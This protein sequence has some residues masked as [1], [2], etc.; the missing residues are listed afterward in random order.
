MSPVL[1]SPVLPSDP[2]SIVSL[3][4]NPEFRTAL[5]GFVIDLVKED[6]DFRE[7]MREAFDY[8]AATSDLKI[9]KRLAVVETDLGHNDLADFEEGHKPTIPEQIKMLSDR[10]EQPLNKSNDSI[11]IE[12]PV[13]PKTTLEHKAGELV[14]HLKTNVKP[15]NG[16]VFL[17]SREIMTFL[18]NEIKEEYQMK[19]IQNPRQAK[20][21]I[22]EKAKKMFSDFIVLD[23]K[24]HGNKDIRIVYK[25][26]SDIMSRKCMN[27]YIHL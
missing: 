23:K 25:P 10:L 15:R 11:K 1:S 18:K 22:I 4:L 14:E 2:A 13:I 24:K 12:L 26:K 7:S 21:D 17:N 9:L 8:S 20:K 6:M 16:E 19:D 3:F 27:P 5:K